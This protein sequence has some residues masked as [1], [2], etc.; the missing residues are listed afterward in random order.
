MEW[1]QI[2]SHWIDYKNKIKSNWI[3]L[4]NDQ[5]DAISGH[6]ELLSQQLQDTYGFDNA[7]AELQ[8]SAWESNLFDL[9]SD[10]QIDDQTDLNHKLKDSQFTN[11][12]VKGRDVIIDSPYH[13]GY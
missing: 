3:E 6:R 11:E 5:I 8:I 9:D 4:T 12:A 2:K 7:E 10:V 1:N 13:K